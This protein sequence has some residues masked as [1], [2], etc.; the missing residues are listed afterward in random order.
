MYF[1]LG[2][3]ERDTLSVSAF[4]ALIWFNKLDFAVL[5]CSLNVWF[6]YVYVYFISKFILK[7][8]MVFFANVEVKICI[9]K[10][11]FYSPMSKYWQRVDKDMSK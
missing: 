4:M 11:N 6:N 3:G 5:V 1:S 9:F 7:R 2:G 10:N 8:S